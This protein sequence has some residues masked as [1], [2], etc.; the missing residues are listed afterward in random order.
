M[1]AARTL[2]LCAL[3]LLVAAG[4]AAARKARHGVSAPAPA[5]ATAEDALLEGEAIL[6]AVQEAGYELTPEELALLELETAAAPALAPGEPANSQSNCWSVRLQ[7]RLQL[8]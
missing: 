7:T 4:P 1:Q 3:L 2:A 5:P 8:R 6:R